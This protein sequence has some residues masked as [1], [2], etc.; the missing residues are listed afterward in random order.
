LRWR[1]ERP[2]SDHDGP[3]ANIATRNPRARK[4][5][6]NEEREREESRE[7]AVEAK[8]RCCR[9]PTAPESF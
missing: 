4:R 1:V 7:R 9:R 2:A 3:R 8:G 5:G 6:R